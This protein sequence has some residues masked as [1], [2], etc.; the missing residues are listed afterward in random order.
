MFKKFLSVLLSVI[1]LTNLAPMVFATE[2][3]EEKTVK[4]HNGVAELSE[5]VIEKDG[6]I[7]ANAESIAK[8]FKPYVNTNGKERFVIK[9]NDI[10]LVF[11]LGDKYVLFSKDKKTISTQPVNFTQK[12]TGTI[13]HKS[14]YFYPLSEIL[15]WMNV[16][17]AVDNG[18]MVIKP[19]IKSVWE[20]SKDMLADEKLKF[21]ILNEME[22]D[23]YTVAALVAANV[24]TDFIAILKFD[25]PGFLKLDKG[26]ENS[27]YSLFNYYD[28]FIDM[29][30]DDFMASSEAEAFI[31][32]IVTINKLNDSI[33]NVLFGT[34]KDVDLPAILTEYNV[35]KSNWDSYIEMNQ[36]FETMS[37]I[38]T[39]ASV[40]NDSLKVLKTVETAAYVLPDYLDALESQ[41]SNGA[42]ALAYN[43]ALSKALKTLDTKKNALFVTLSDELVSFVVDKAVDVAG[44]S[45][46]LTSAVGCVDAFLSL[47]WPVNESADEITRLPIYYNIQTSAYK[48]ATECKF[49]ATSLENVH[50]MRVN[51]MLSL[52]ASKQ[53]YEAMQSVLNLIKQGHLKDTDIERL[54]L[55]M[56][57]IAFAESAEENDV[58]C[59]KSGKAKE[60][61][62]LFNN[63]SLIDYINPDYAKLFTML[64]YSA[65]VATVNY[66]SREINSSFCKD[67]DSDGATELFIETSP[68]CEYLSHSVLS[69]EPLSNCS[70]TALYHSG[71][72][73]DAYLTASKDGNIFL[74]YTYGSGSGGSI[75]MYQYNDNNWE[76]YAVL[77]LSATLNEQDE[78]VR[79][80][81]EIWYKGTTDI[82]DE[83]WQEKIDELKLEACENHF[84]NMLYNHI[85]CADAKD[86]VEKY[87]AYLKTNSNTEIELI[88]KDFDKDGKTEYGFILYNFIN[89][90]TNNISDL[91]SEIVSLEEEITEKFFPEHVLIYG[92]TDTTGISF[93]TYHLGGFPVETWET[94]AEEKIWLENL[95]SRYASSDV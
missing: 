11:N 29:A 57:E 8:I 37:K 25:I 9:E 41:K 31:E 12:Y 87:A 63:V 50:L 76:K 19:D 67:A 84:D 92:K 85:D 13:V 16:E 79:E 27:F 70:M 3:Y 49:N 62:K 60:I 28:A 72:A 30:S 90:W 1:I 86:V 40:V 38:A 44:L 21:N 39:T 80:I 83:E 78:Y 55:K 48:K 71:V 34:N 82:T 69:F 53:S 81:H 35:D 89:N 56:T 91:D 33:K 93:K 65:I 61:K 66:Y 68:S 88:E 52:L 5:S 64:D 26:Y 43:A 2:S 42:D 23:A 94:E 77:S 47:V 45:V 54:N 73:G 24:I 14:M 95:I 32:D 74:K 6:E 15:P 4:I 51:Y 59:D 46:S 7:Y 36:K 58:I 75:K 22:D 17:C 18:V 20:I 10:N